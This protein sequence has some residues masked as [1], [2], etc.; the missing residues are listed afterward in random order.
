MK[1][2]RLL[3][4]AA[5]LLVV[6]AAAI[7]I[8]LLCRKKKDTTLFNQKADLLR[9]S[10]MEDWVGVEVGVNPAG[11]AGYAVFLSVCNGEERASVYTGVGKNL[12][13]A[14]DKA[15]TRTDKALKKSGLDPKW[16]KAD[17]SPKR[18]R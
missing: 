17:V 14:W 16:L 12:V 7:A 4:L 3:C 18:I 1:I 13:T 11:N 2:K 9:E 6:V 5:I 10:V 15:V 8:P